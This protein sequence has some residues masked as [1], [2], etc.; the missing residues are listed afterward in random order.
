MQY[1]YYANSHHRNQEGY[2]YLNQGIEFYC[3]YL[4]LRIVIHPGV[5]YLEVLVGEWN[6]RGT[7]SSTFVKRQVTY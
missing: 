5:L 6:R 3:Y 1:D 7:L 2:S 4:I